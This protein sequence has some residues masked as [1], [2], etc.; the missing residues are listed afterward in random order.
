MNPSEIQIGSREQLLY[1]LAEASEIEHNLMCCYLYAAWSLKTEADDGLDEALRAELKCWQHVIFKVAIDEM[2]HLALVANLMNAIGGSAHFSRPNFPIANGYHPAGLQV[3][4]A[5]FTRAT[6]Q[7]FIHLERPEGSDEPDGEG[8]EPSLDY[9]RALYGIQ[10]TPSAQDFPT[11]GHL[12]KAVERGLIGLSETL[13]EGVLFCGD[14]ALQVGPTLANLPGLIAVTDLTSA[15]K[16]IET[17]VE[18]GEG[19]PAHN[20]DSHFER[21]VGL[22]TAYETLLAANPGLVPAYPVANNPV[23]RKPVEP[24]GRVWVQHDAPRAVM[25]IGNAVYNHMLRF[26]VQAF[27]DTDPLR[28]RQFLDGGIDMM[29]ALDPLARELA[30]LKANDSD[31][32][33]AGISFTTLRSYPSVDDRAAP[34][35]LT[36]RLGELKEGLP[37]LPK[38]PRVMAALHALQQ[39]YGRLAPQNAP[40]PEKPLNVDSPAAPL[41]AAPAPAAPETA[42]KP[43]TVEGTD[44][45]LIFDAKRC[46]H[47]RF[48]VTGAPKTF[49]ANVPGEWLF[50]DATPLDYLVEIAHACPSGAISY[51]RKDGKADETPPPVNLINIRENGPYAVR[52]DLMLVGAAAG[53]R[54]TLCRC[55]ASKNKPFCDGSHHDIAF[56]ASGEPQTISLDPLT[57]RDGP[58]TV[59]P[60][61]NGP[62]KVEGNLEICAGTGRVVQRV[63]QTRLCRCGQSQTKPFCDGS[64][65]AAGFVAEGSERST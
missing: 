1:T 28:K 27:A 20:A 64:H 47:A 26:L 16:A 49:L 4:L 38:T 39:T 17:I 41:P 40:S 32:C 37:S 9:S 24:A 11:V 43:E 36:E 29:F 44:M 34:V 51:R 25:D 3:H 58:L 46:I 15:V 19:S 45:T 52:G 33:N 57:A 55:G 30:R 65:R 59:E 8:F 61:R 62:L 12:Y 42:S 18:Q 14:P 60:Q 31:D 48:C 10:L 2:S 6:L 21:F 35:V 22:R 63:T 53:T 56:G 5:P 13:G 23:M 50:P 7:H 54:A